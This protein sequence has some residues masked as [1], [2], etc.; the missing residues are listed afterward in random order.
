[1]EL[2]VNYTYTDST[3]PNTNM[4]TA[5]IPYSVTTGY[6]N[7]SPIDKLTLHIDGRYIGTRYDDNNHTH[8]TGRYTVFDG[9]IAYNITKDLK[10][11]LAIYNIFN[12]F[13]QDIWG[14]TTLKRSAY[15]TVSY[16]F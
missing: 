5:R 6:I 7:Y 4:Q 11:S 8:Q 15:A 14:Y 13:Y 10:A 12:R 1:M 3:N 2:G 9:N 16:T